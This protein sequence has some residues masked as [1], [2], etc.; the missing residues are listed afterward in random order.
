MTSEYDPFLAPARPRFESSNLDLARGL[1]AEASRPYLVSPLPWLAWAGILPAAAL[2]TPTLLRRFEWIGVLLLWSFAI[3]IGG[4]FELAALRRSAGE[5]VSTA[6]ASW[7]FGV[8]ANLSL[9]SIALSLLLLWIE[10]AWAL[11]G[12]WLLLLGHSLVILG[13]LA[14]A[15][16]R[17]AGLVYQ[18]GG[19]AALWP[20]GEPLLVLAITTGAANLWM[21]AAVARQVRRVGAPE[22]SE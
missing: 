1:F 21:A 2:L 5:M 3:L 15:P 4:G 11:P 7:A 13:G 19:V 18:I 22:P 16:M 17:V 20:R 12:L 14:F 6:L 8:Q 9:V 10:A